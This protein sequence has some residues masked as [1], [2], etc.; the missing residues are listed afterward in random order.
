MSA[1]QTTGSLLSR[2]Y[3]L[4]RRNRTLYE[5]LFAY[6]GDGNGF[7]VK[8]SYF[9]LLVISLSRMNHWS[10]V[11]ANRHQSTNGSNCFVDFDANNR[12]AVQMSLIPGL[13]HISGVRRFQ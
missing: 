8:P 2:F 6:E 11:E 4:R 7:V 13:G 3:E 12:R 9:D 5:P 1:A 10:C